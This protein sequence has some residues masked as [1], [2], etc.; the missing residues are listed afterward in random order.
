MPVFSP[1]FLFP[2]KKNIYKMESYFLFGTETVLILHS[3]K[4]ILSHMKEKTCLQSKKSFIKH[5]KTVIRSSSFIYTKM[6]F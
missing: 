6:F 1:R 5:D 2:S 3:I 4:I